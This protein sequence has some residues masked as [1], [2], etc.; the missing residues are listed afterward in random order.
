M[1]QLPSNLLG[2][3][4]EDGCWF[5]LENLANDGVEDCLVPVVGL[6]LRKLAQETEVN[7]AG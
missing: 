7:S 6:L 4:L 5:F 3:F 2:G 1:L